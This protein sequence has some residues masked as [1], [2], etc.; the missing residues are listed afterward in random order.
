MSTTLSP[1]TQLHDWSFTVKEDE[2]R[3]ASSVSPGP[4]EFFDAYKSLGL[5]ESQNSVDGSRTDTRY[6]EQFL[7]RC[8]VDFQGKLVRMS[9]RPHCLGIN[10]RRQITL[11]VEYEVGKAKAISAKQKI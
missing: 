9:S 7:S 2:R 6:S 4:L 5:P 3:S 11:F 8:A 1:K 10:I